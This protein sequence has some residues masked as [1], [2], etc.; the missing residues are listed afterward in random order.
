MPTVRG[1]SYDDLGR[2]GV[3]E[4]NRLYWDGRPVVVQERLALAWWVNVAVV[5]GALSTLALATIE[6]LRFCGLGA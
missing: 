2:L 6:A 3:D 5:V 1:I 4:D